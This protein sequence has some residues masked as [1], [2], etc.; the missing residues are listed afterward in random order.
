MTLTALGGTGTCYG[1]RSCSHV[2]VQA[3]SLLHAWCLPSSDLSLLVTNPRTSGSAAVSGFGVPSSWTSFVCPLGQLSVLPHP[4]LCTGAELPSC[5]DR[6]L[7]P[8]APRWAWRRAGEWSWSIYSPPLL[9]SGPLWVAVPQRKVT[10]L[11]GSPC[12]G[13]RSHSPRGC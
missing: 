9:V 12:G 10:V 7:C 3:L 13:S 5:R 8:L 2:L 11:T 4:T 6:L 1:C